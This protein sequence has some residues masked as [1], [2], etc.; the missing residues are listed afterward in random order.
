MLF[1]SSSNY[2]NKMIEATSYLAKAKELH[3]ELEE[4]YIAAMDF[5]V[6]ERIQ[7]KIAEEIRGLAA[8]K[9]E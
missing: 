1:R 5:S 3:D 8:T 6:V 7:N 9:V 2:K 4:I